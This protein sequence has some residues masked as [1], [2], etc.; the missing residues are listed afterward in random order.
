MK[1]PRT[2]AFGMLLLA[3]AAGP[4]A[5]GL[6]AGGTPVA[7]EASVAL[8]VQAVLEAQA[9]AAPPTA[10]P[11]TEVP[12]TAEVSP[13]PTVTLTATA[14]STQT[15]IPTLCDAA[16]FVADVT[17]PDDTEILVNGDFTKT[18]RLRNVGTCTWTSGY[19]LIFDHG[20]RM[21][22]PDSVGLTSGTVPPG[23]TVDVSVNLKAPSELGTYQGFFLL[24]SPSNVV[25]G[26][27]PSASSPFWVK[28][29][30]TQMLTIVTLMPLFPLPLPIVQ[31]SGTG[32]IL[33]GG[34]CFN[35]DD[36]TT[37]GCGSADADFEFEATLMD[38]EI[39]PRSPAAFSSAKTS[40]PTYSDCSGASL[41]TSN[42]DLSMNRWYCYKTSQD[43][44]GWI[45][46]TGFDLLTMVFDWKTW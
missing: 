22:A 36:G 5:C 2:F 39:D 30:A 45:K 38:H 41:S 40:E 3:L 23:A 14:T 16:Q 21:S 20:D 4:L 18:W 1:H 42:R 46:V 6:P 19:Q 43:N 11:P 27:G 15:P 12:P 34:K 24:R 10:A 32:A 25:F 35:L 33:G 17:I 44:Y 31:S 7:D 37:E 9:T 28:I 26:I 29:K 13:T 8:T